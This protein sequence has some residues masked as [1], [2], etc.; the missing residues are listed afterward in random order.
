MSRTKKEKETVGFKVFPGQEDKIVALGLKFREVRGIGSNVD[1]PFAYNLRPRYDHWLLRTKIKTRKNQLQWV[2]REI[3]DPD[4]VFRA[5]V[6]K[7]LLGE[8]EFENVSGMCCFDFVY[9][10]TLYSCFMNGEGFYSVVKENA[11]QDIEDATAEEIREL[12]GRVMR[13]KNIPEKGIGLCNPGKAD[14]ELEEVFAQTVY[15][16]T[17]AA[18]IQFRLDQKSIRDAFNRE[19]KYATV[20]VYYNM[21][22]V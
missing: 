8:L 6:R 3:G 4:G 16:G 15:T 14:Y 20:N 10:G 1:V 19:I 22:E 21:Q 12:Q 2:Y 9:N 13:I 11:Q 18:K 17:E 5:I 7:V